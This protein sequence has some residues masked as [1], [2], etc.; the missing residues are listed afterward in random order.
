[1]KKR[2]TTRGIVEGAMIAAICSYLLR[3]HKKLVPMPPVI[4]NGLII[5]A[6]L[7]FV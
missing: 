3:D 2:M 4:A 6:M 1:M 7:H 5:G